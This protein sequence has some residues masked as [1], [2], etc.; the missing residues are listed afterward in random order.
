MGAN[1]NKAK[2]TTAAR[3]AASCAPSQSSSRNR[4]PSSSQVPTTLL[5]RTLATINKWHK[6]ERTK[7]GYKS[8]V[9]RGMKW[10]QKWVV[11]HA[12]SGE[13]E[14]D[15]DSEDICDNMKDTFTVISEQTPIAL[16]LL[17]AY[18]CDE[19]KCKFSTAEGIRSAF[20]DYFEK[21]ISSLPLSCDALCSIQEFVELWVAKEIYGFIMHIVKNGRA[22]LFLNLHTRHTTNL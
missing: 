16:R 11:E 15:D 21:Y 13:E 19:G 10:L 5:H 2:T 12:G 22:I 14:G 9:N 18:K 17:T 8:H 20:K 7:A 3:N 1:R 4:Q 6:S